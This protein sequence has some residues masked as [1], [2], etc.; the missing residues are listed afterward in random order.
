MSEFLLS[1]GRCSRSFTGF[2][3][4]LSIS[5]VGCNLGE[6]EWV[7]LKIQFSPNL[8]SLERSR[9]ARRFSLLESCNWTSLSPSFNHISVIFLSKG[10]LVISHPTSI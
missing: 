3:A 10:K 8:G 5:G 2:R 4:H 6:I 1:L 7:F 9:C